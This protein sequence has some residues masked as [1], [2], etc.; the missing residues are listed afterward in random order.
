MPA[1]EGEVLAELAIIGARFPGQCPKETAQ[2]WAKDLLEHGFEVADIREAGRKL[3]VELTNAKGRLFVGDIIEHARIARRKRV[4]VPLGGPLLPARS[5]ATPDPLRE[6]AISN[7]ARR[8]FEGER[9]ADEHWE[10]AFEQELKR[11]R[12]QE[13]AKE[14]SKQ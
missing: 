13:R 11:L 12:A 8:W 3:G 4:E 1:S 14:E 10:P 5:T 2:I 7:V 9:F 6:K